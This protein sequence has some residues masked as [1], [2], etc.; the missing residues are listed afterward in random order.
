MNPLS[1]R[2]FIRPAVLGDA[3]TIAAIHAA[4]FGRGWS[5]SEVES[6]LVQDTVIGLLAERQRAFGK[7]QP[8]GFV[9]IR[10]AA[11]EA[12]VLSIAVQP[13]YQRRGIGRAL[14]EEGLRA[15]YRDRVT[16]LHLEVDAQNDP[17][18]NLYKSLEFQPT[19]ER[20]DY[21]RQARIAS[22]A[23]PRAALVMSRQVR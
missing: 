16:A 9:M 22:G 17:A 6:L 7:R 10:M 21:Y 4:A 2:T 8:A 20:P 5:D 23:A 3:D 15:L 1:A 18:V 19:G 12:E 13:A 11:D 14:M